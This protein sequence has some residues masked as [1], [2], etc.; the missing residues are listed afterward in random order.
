[1]ATLI[2]GKAIAAKVRAEAKAAAATLKAERGVIPGLA[3]VLVGSDQASKTYVAS[4]HKASA[5][6]GLASW[7]HDL[8][9]TTTQADLLALVDKLNRDPAVH[10]ILV[11]LPLPKGLD[12]QVVISAISPAK[13]VDGFHPLS[14]GKL[15]AG[16]PGPRPCTPAGI[17]RMLDELKCDLKG[18]NAVVIGRSNIVGKPIA[19]MLLQRHATVTICHSRTADLAAEVSRGDVVVAALGK[20]RAIQ[21]GWIKAG[22]VVIDV[23][24]NRDANG[25][26]CGD[27][28][29]ESAK[30]RA[31]AITPVPGGVGPMTV[32]MLIAA[33]VEAAKQQ[34]G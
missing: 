12:E 18:K 9:E 30:E 5:E 16:L 1:M 22:A 17:M 25:K 13:D 20:A 31:S 32:A 7:Q 29:F 15:L 2:D 4:K 8:P 28:D 21:G 3:T 6:A 23:G 10:G 11:Q 14:S 34:T 33:T 27:V 19:L 24:I 26:M